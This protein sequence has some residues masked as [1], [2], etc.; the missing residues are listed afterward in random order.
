MVYSTETALVAVTE[1]LH[2]DIEAKL[3]SILIL[4]DLSAAFNMVNH[5]APLSILI[6]LGI[7]GRPW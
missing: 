4:V 7:C 3:L 1:K 6:S 5:K 2:A